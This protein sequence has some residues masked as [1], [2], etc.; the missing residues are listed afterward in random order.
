MAAIWDWPQK[1][2]EI[3]GAGGYW[4]QEGKRKLETRGEL[5]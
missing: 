4:P 2:A 1:N 5:G 3:E